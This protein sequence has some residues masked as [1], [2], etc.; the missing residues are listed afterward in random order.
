V[1]TDT[2]KARSGLAPL[3]ARWRSLPRVARWVILAG[4]GIGAYYGIVEP[5]LDMTNKADAAADLA[6][7]Q[8][9]E[10]DKQEASRAEAQARIAIGSTSFG[11]VAL[12]TKDANLVSRISD[13]IAAILNDHGVTE[14]NVQTLR[15]SPLGRAVLPSLFRPDTEELQRVVFTVTLS[16]RTATVLSVIADLERIP[17]IAAISSAQL[18]RTEKGK[19]RIAATLSPEVWVIVPREA[20]R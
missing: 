1:T 18:R 17:G 11:E 15:G 20:S 9:R 14:W 12:P 8:L 16:D 19:D 3:V 4:L 10:Y 2:P 7:L 5:V 13:Q 6:A